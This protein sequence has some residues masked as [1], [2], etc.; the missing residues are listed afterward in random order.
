MVNVFITL[1][2]PPGDRLRLVDSDVDNLEGF[3]PIKPEMHGA[4]EAIIGN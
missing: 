1:F 4:I 2:K 3:V